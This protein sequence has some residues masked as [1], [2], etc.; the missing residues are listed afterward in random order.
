LAEKYEVT[1]EFL[2][3]SVEEEKFDELKGAGLT[4]EEIKK[5]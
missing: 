4:D 3:E 1:V 2:T 5:L